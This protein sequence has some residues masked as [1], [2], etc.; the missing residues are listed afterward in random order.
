[1]FSFSSM[2]ATNVKAGDTVQEDGVLLTKE[3]AAKIIADKKTAE[4]KCEE[5]IK[6]NKKMVEIDKNLDINNLKSDLKAEKEKS[7]ITL[8]LKDK[9]IERLYEQLE[10]E[11]GKSN[12]VLLGAGIGVVATAIVTTAI[13]FASVQIVKGGQL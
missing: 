1:M 8:E 5:D 2:A 9:E 11:Q 13:F 12:G 3:E 10:K 4:K 7:E 6:F